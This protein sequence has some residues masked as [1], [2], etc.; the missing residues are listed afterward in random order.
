MERAS[1]RLASKRA[2][3]RARFTLFGLLPIKPIL[4]VMMG[5][6]VTSIEVVA[7]DR[8]AG[9]GKIMISKQMYTCQHN[10]CSIAE[11]RCLSSSVIFP[12]KL[13]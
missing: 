4:L 3:S 11:K 5:Q 10:I 6:L 1:A 2:S 7:G 13:R 8:L 9:D 12:V